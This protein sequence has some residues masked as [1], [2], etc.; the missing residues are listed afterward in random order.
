MK[1]E[2]QI[3]INEFIKKVL[4]L[5]VISIVLF[6]SFARKENTNYSDLDMLVVME[7]LP[8][9]WSDRIE[10]LVP[11]TAKIAMEYGV[12]ISPICMTKD[13]VLDNLHAKTPMFIDM[14]RGY[15]VLYDKGFFVKS[16]REFSE[17]VSKIYIYN[18][19]QKVWIES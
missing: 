14:T 7:D 11:I 9:K 1:K 17:E 3:A 13:E 10:I 5:K 2:Y 16:I 15:K 12:T 4:K 19:R 8:E 18:K 6:G